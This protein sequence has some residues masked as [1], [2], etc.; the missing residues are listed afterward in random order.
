MQQEN[1]SSTENSSHSLVEAMMQVCSGLLLVCQIQ[2]RRSMDVQFTRLKRSTLRLIQ[3]LITKSDEGDLLSLYG[4]DRWILVQLQG[5]NGLTDV[6]LQSD[7]LDTLLLVIS[8]QKNGT[9]RFNSTEPRQSHHSRPKH[10]LSWGEAQDPKFGSIS[11]PIE[12]D[13][14]LAEPPEQILT[15]LLQGAETPVAQIILEKWVRALCE[16]TDL[17]QSSIYRATMQI[18]DVL[19]RQI[20]ACFVGIQSQFENGSV[21]EGNYVF[22]LLC[23][24]D[25][26]DFALARAHKRLMGEEGIVLPSKSSDVQHGFLG[27]IVAGSASTDSRH[28]RL[29]TSNDRLT[30]M[31]CFQDAVKTCSRLW[32]WQ[33]TRPEGS[34]DDIS[35]SQHVVHKVRGRS[36]KILEHMSNAEA[37]QV[38]EV[39]A[40]IWVDAIQ[41][42]DFEYSRA[43]INLIHTLEGSSPRR[44]VVP[45]FN[46]IMTR[47]NADA[48]PVHD[49][50]SLSTSLGEQ[51]L[52]NFLIAYTN[53][54][55]EDALDEIWEDCAKFL[56]EI[57]ENPMANR[58][59]IIPSMEY[60]FILYVKLENASVSNEPR[61]R[62]EIRELFVQLLTAAFATKPQ[63]VSQEKPESEGS[64][65][66]MSSSPV[67]TVTTILDQRFD[68]LLA[69]LEES[70]RHLSVMTT[71]TTNAVTPLFRSR[72]FPNNLISQ[73]LSLL[74]QIS[75]TPGALKAWKKEV[76]DSFNDAK[77]F[78]SPVPLARDG[79]L[80]LV[81]Q[82][83]LVDKDFLSELLSRF[84]PP[85][86]AGIMFGVGAAVARL[87]ADKRTQLNL[88][89]VTTCLLAVEEERLAMEIPLLQ[90]K[91]EE[92]LSASVSSSPSS[93]TRAEVFILMRALVLI[94]S[95]KHMFSFWPVINLELETVFRALLTAEPVFNS[96][97]YTMQSILQA[98]KLVDVLLLTNPEDFQPQEW[99]FVTDTVDAVYRPDTGYPIGLIDEL[100]QSSM[101]DGAHGQESLPSLQALS[102]DEEQCLQVPMLMG[103]KTRGCPDGDIPDLILKPFF[104]Q[105]SIQVYER[106][107]KLINPDIKTCKDDLLADLFNLRTIAG[108]SR[109]LEP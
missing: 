104:R 14:G 21:H 95:S 22:R 45:L 63:A 33:I 87:E 41:S 16:M 79:W 89:R 58:H 105:L 50:S 80:P 83:A 85:A 74:L 37:L 75:K 5:Q 10:R 64:V 109:E 53:L 39:L 18:V 93:A 81:R 51:D 28:D 101:E 68:I 91:V 48:L 107:Y 1:T 9:I 82:I 102:G 86:S 11:P 30:L 70:D 106:T 76:V 31:L 49:R 60:I 103:E 88:R 32:S 96:S 43:V 94:G 92:L 71:I 12:H 73:T 40:R 69:L 24:L 72:S 38:V 90:E 77:L 97:L 13:I 25:G 98:S 35:S 36:R 27:S 62:R 55:D 44:T 47:T 2:E 46:A 56:H 57:L 52:V 42:R 6:I 17:Y 59:I 20:H 54:L 108:H 19:C 34:N 7:L 4:V 26:L 65:T 78:A 99:V 100:A 8:A 15:S 23:Y 29:Q 84:S 61:I 3:T 67:T 66:A